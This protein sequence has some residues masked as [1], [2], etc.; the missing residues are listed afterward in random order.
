MTVSA[1]RLVAVGFFLHLGTL[2]SLAAQERTPCSFDACALRIEDGRLVEGR[3]GRSVG[4]VRIFR[5]DLGVLE[6]GPD[7][8]AW[9]AAAY[10]SNVKK[11]F[12]LG[13]GGSLLLGA[14]LAFVEHTS[15]NR[16]LV[17]IGV[18]ATGFGL[19]VLGQRRYRTAGTAIARSVWFYNEG[20]AEG[21]Y[22]P[23]R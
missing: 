20:I 22:R 18:G 3:D 21:T 14:G 15:G 11:G 9:Y 23:G 10:R 17:S 6:A 4:R 2:P 16:Q 13:M 1:L 8:A 7:S 19:Q 5:S 12:F